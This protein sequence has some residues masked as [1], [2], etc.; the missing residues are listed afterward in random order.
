MYVLFGTYDL[1][2]LRNA[3][4]QLGSRAVTVHFNRYKPDSKA[5]RRDF[6]DVLLSLVAHMPLIETP[7]LKKHIEYCFEISL[8]CIGLLKVWLTDALGSVLEGGRKT[9]CQ[10][11]L[12]KC[13][14]SIDVLD[15]IS[16]SSLINSI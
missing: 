14:P 15:N 3:N 2:K 1:L 11:D 8:G 6:A 4:G 10:G 13:E 9:L 5:D 7:D 12:E 16:R